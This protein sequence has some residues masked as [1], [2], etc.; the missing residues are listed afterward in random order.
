MNR[1]ATLKPNDD[2]RVECVRQKLP[3]ESADPSA[4]Q[5]N[6]KHTVHGKQKRAIWWVGVV[7]LDEAT[8]QVSTL[9]SAVSRV[10]RQAVSSLK[11]S[12][13]GWGGGTVRC[14]HGGSVGVQAGGSSSSSSCV[15]CTV[16][17]SASGRRSVHSL[18][19]RP[20]DYCA[21]LDLSY[22]KEAL[23]PV[24]DHTECHSIPTLPKKRA[25]TIIGTTR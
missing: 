4:A 8:P 20:T 9:S 24:I 14:L 15:H 1:V 21:D 19:D 13:V 3:A 10:I 16:R 23:T 6:Y 25:S 17:G 11:L 7:K 18:I 5:A 22:F 12:T 2:R